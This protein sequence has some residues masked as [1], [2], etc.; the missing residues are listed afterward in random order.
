MRQL[1]EIS[2][3][4]ERAA[5]DIYRRIIANLPVIGDLHQRTIIDV[6]VSYGRPKIVR[7]PALCLRKHQR[8]AIDRSRTRISVRA[9][10]VHRQRSAATFSDPSVSGTDAS[11]DRRASR[12]NDREVV[13][14][15]G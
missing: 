5:V 15:R 8:A 2:G 12:T 14:I 1:L 7:R 6:E 9:R 3:E 11:R 4:I 13:R 10:A